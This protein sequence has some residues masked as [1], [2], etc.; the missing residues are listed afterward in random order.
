MIC[1]HCIILLHS[2]L[3]YGF[4]VWGKHISNYLS[5]IITLQNKAKTAGI[6][7]RNSW[8]LPKERGREGL[9]PKVKIFL[10]ESVSVRWHAEQTGAT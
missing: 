6:L 3:I 7:T 2:H 5:I 9:E 8:I 10:F 4:F 1:S